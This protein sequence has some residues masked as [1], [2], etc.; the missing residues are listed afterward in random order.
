MSRLSTYP[1]EIFDSWAEVYDT[2]PNPLLSL[3]QRILGSRLGDVR[4]LDIVD[5]GCGTGRWLQQLAGRGP[6]SLIGVDISPAMLLLAGAKL[7]HNCDL[8]LG[9]CAVLPVGDTATDMVL[10]SFVASYLDDLDAFAQEVDRIARP[11]ATVFLSDMHPDTEARFNWKRGFQ[12]NGTDTQIHG[13]KWSLQQITQAFADRGF[14][15]FSLM[16]PSFSTEERQ[17]FEE[18]GR[19]DL[20][21]S[22]R[23]LPAIY[24]L[25]LRKPPSSPR[26]R[27]AASYTPGAIYLT[28][29]RC[30]VGAD[31]SAIASLS[32]DGQTIHS[33]ESGNSE[34]TVDLSGFLLL[35]GLIN[36]HDHLDFSLFPNIGDG[37]YQSA[38]EWADD[39][40]SNQAALIARYRR[41]PRSLRLW[42][43]GIRNLLCG[44]TTVCHHNPLSQ[45]LLKP[46]FPVRAMS[47]FA[48]AHSPSLEP[49]LAGK[50]RENRADLPFVLHAA[51]GV[52]ERSSHEVFDLDRIHVLDDRTVLVH[53]LACTA[54]GVSLINQRRT[55][56]ILCPTSN[57]FL[58]HRSPSL[59]FIRSL[60]SVILGSDS[61]LT[62]AGDLLDEI[63]FVHT[64]TGLDANSIYAMVTNRPAEI[65]RLRQGEGYVKPGSVADLLVV[66]DTGLS[67]A[68]TLMQLT[69]DQIELVMVGGRIQLAGEWLYERLPDGLKQGL[70]RFEV[71]GHPRWVRAPIDRLFAET[72]EFLGGDLCV[73][74]R[75]VRRAPAA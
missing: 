13:R 50:F 62:A 65:L 24:V 57:E 42:W 68:E 70:Q 29:G 63:R 25:Q 38:A 55:S 20:Y 49:D 1:S 2:Q 10:S 8:R 6:R 32:I 3:E 72:E 26:V 46:E 59:G 51:E 17:I 61:P 73:G 15:V 75:R 21:E 66:R 52:D 47:D 74:G 22:A 67:P 5:A 60:E 11:G 58:F 40:H 39:I 53:G 27:K 56:V 16:E 35:P 54:Q 41:V 18:C 43:G 69:H 23:A 9:N 71:N 4:G 34:S 7:D 19:L 48:W 64:Q 12:A 44:V 14:K 31:V 28:G 37:P 45:E 30:A 33:I 36:A